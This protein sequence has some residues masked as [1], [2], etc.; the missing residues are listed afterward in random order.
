M[1]WN[2]EALNFLYPPDSFSGVF[3]NANMQARHEE[4]MQIKIKVLKSAIALETDP[5]KAMNKLHSNDHLQ[6]LLNNRNIFQEA[7]RLE[8][9]LLTLYS[10][11]H[12]PF[13]SGGDVSMWS[14]LFET[15]DTTSLYKLGDPVPFVS[16]T[17]YRGA[18]MGIKRS[19]SWSADR[20][21]AELFFERWQDPVVGGGQ[22][23]EVDISK[24]NVLVRLKQSRESEIIL[25]PTFIKSAEIRVF[26]PQA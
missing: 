5:A 17:V 22:I 2:T 7:G 4:Q 23:Y 12:G 13:S 10:R 18:A 19:L 25:A 26:N 1:K 8:E 16:A 6:F 21:R 11:R 9:V 15:C 14:N 20:Q 24:K 3:D